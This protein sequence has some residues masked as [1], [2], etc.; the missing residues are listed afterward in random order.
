M[1]LNRSD[2]DEFNAEILQ[3]Q[4]R[5]LYAINFYDELESLKE[6]VFWNMNQNRKDKEK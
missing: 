5:N 1:K 2:I 6:N 3:L 4:N